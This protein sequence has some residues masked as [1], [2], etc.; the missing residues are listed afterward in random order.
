[1]YLQLITVRGGWEYLGS[2]SAWIERMLNHVEIVPGMEM[3][4]GSFPPFYHQD[5]MLKRALEKAKQMIS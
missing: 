1:M 4:G 2:D 3:T 5:E